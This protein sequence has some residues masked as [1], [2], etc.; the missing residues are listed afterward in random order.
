MASRMSKLHVTKSLEPGQPGAVRLTQK[1]DDELLCVGYRQ[2]GLGL[3]RYTTVELIVDEA[4]N[5]A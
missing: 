1:Y 2:D 4:Q 3:V 5:S